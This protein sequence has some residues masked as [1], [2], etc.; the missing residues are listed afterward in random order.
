VWW[1]EPPDDEPRPFVI[2]TRNEAIAGLEKLV[3]VPTTRT[4]RGIPSE[5][6]L[7]REDGMPGDC[8]VSTDN[9]TVGSQG[10]ADPADHHAQPPADGRGLPRTCLRDRLL[11]QVSGSALG[12]PHRVSCAAGA[13]LPARSR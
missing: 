6:E 3:A 5:V 7:G 4:I 1:H 13:R 2:L 9:I 12:R 11:R 10:A 8:V